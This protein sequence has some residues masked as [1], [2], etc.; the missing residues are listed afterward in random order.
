ME[1]GMAKNSGE[2]AVREETGEEL[3]RGLGAT[4]RAVLELLRSGETVSGT[5]KSA[6]VSRRTIHR[7][8]RSDAAFGAAYNEWHEEV[9]EGCR[10]RLA[11]LAHEAT[12]ALEKAL[13]KGVTR[14]HE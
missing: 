9:E 12:M 11:M 10:S 14:P 7:W 1:A 2:L 4:Q 6:G 13:K 3:A 8:I 5:A